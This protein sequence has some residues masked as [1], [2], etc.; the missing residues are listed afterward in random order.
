MCTLIAINLTSGGGGGFVYQSAKDQLRFNNLSIKKHISVMMIIG[1]LYTL[2]KEDW[3][4]YK[5]DNNYIGITKEELIAF[6]AS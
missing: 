3:E 4:K 6:M 1:S 2:P 5:N